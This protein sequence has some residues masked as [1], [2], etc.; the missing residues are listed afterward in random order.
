MEFN[1]VLVIILMAVGALIAW[2]ALRSQGQQG[3]LEL[4]NRRIAF[5]S[6]LDGRL[7]ERDTRRHTDPMGFLAEKF[8]QANVKTLYNDLAVGESR[9]HI[10]NF[11]TAPPM[12][13]AEQDRL[14]FNLLASVHFDL[15]EL[16]KERDKL[17]TQ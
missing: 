13:K 5:Y 10:G 6:E 2:L 1:D 8:A 11:L 3:A 7:N 9:I 14:L 15:E 16:K 12:Y 4:L 17:T